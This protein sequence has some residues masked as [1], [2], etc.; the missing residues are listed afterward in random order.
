LRKRTEAL[1][2]S[3]KHGNRQPGEVGGMG[4]LQNVPEIWEVKESQDSKGRTQDEMLY[5]GER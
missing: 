3:R 1:R 4:T 2:A 5:C